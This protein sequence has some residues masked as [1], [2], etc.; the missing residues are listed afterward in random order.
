MPS[1]N[2]HPWVSRGSHQDLALQ[3]DAPALGGRAG[4]ESAQGPRTG[5]SQGHNLDNCLRMPAG[6]DWGGGAGGGGTERTK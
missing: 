4:M 6:W 2:P 5:V 3:M 1:V